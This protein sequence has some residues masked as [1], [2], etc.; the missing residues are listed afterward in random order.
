MK[1]IVLYLGIKCASRMTKIIKITEDESWKNLFLFN[2]FQSD[3]EVF[4]WSYRIR[5]Y[6]IRKYSKNFHVVLKK[7]PKLEVF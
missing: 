6:I 2:S 5:F 4:T 1:M 7:K 3:F